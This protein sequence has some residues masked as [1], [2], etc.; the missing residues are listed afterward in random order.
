VANRVA[1]GKALVRR[2][3]ILHPRD[4]WR[5]IQAGESQGRSF[6]QDQEAAKKMSRSVI[7]SEAKNLSS[8]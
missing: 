7:L 6:P 2:A 1:N 3:G 4:L 5:R 8:I